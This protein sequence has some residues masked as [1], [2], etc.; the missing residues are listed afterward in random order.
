[1]KMK[2]TELTKLHRERGVFDDK[3]HSV[4]YW[5]NSKEVLKKFKINHT[6]L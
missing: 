2:E 3:Q 1:M 4:Y 5:Y 6:S